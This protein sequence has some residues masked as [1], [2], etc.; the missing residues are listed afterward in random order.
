MIE[1]RQLFVYNMDEEDWVNGA[2]GMI[3]K[4]LEIKLAIQ[5]QEL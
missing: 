1:I 5:K 4:Q 3:I 2:F